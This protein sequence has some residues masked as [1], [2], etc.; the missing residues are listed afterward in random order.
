MAEQLKEKT[1]KIRELEKQLKEY[2]AN[3]T[4]IRMKS[5]QGMSSRKSAGK[6]KS[7]QERQESNGMIGADDIPSLKY[8]D[9]K[10]SVLR[11][12]TPLMRR[13]RSN[14]A[15]AIV[16]HVKHGKEEN[17]NNNNKKDKNNAKQ[18]HSDRDAVPLNR[19]F[20][21][22]NITSPAQS[23]RSPLSSRGSD[24]KRASG[25]R[26]DTSFIGRGGGGLVKLK[27]TYPTMDGYIYRLKVVFFLKF[28]CKKKK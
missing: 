17:N 10:T 2:Q 26:K 21:I 8:I 23:P 7:Y 22:T 15:S 6:G 3:C 25:K 24:A 28:I 4:C 12:K 11:L 13:E 9:E 14:S 1:S 20:T 16:K 5:G 19:A 18:D 27:F